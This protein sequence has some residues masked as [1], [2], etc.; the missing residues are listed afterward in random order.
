MSKEK[1]RIPKSWSKLD[2]YFYADRLS[3]QVVAII[4]I[5]LTAGLS[6]AGIATLDYVEGK[7]ARLGILAAF[8]VTFAAVVGILTT[9]RR[10]ELFAA[11]AGFAAVLVVYVG[12]SS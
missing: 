10:T 5:L 2:L 1:R 8:T 3:E 12:S 4:A 7:G 9:A 11:T 6:V